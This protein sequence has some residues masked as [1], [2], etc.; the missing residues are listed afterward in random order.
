MSTVRPTPTCWIS[1]AKVV[2]GDR[3]K[4]SVMVIGLR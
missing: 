4:A 3:A 2:F 1:L